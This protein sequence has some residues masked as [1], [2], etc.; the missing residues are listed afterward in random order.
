MKL[1]LAKETMM[2]FTNSTRLTGASAR[3]HE[4]QSKSGKPRRRIR[5]YW[6]WV[7]RVRSEDA[8]NWVWLKEFGFLAFPWFRLLVTLQILG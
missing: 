7:V 1:C 5:R 3:L 8:G 6:L 4:F 2:S